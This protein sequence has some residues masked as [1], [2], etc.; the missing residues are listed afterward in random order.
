MPRSIAFGRI[1]CIRIDEF[2]YLL[3][4]VVPY[5]EPAPR[6]LAHRGLA[7]DAVENSLRAFEAA[8]D[9]GVNHIETDVRTTRDGVAVLW[10]D[11]DLAAVGFPDVRIRDIDWYELRAM[12][13]G[14]DGIARLDEALQVFPDLKFN[15]DLKDAGA[16][17]PVIDVLRSSQTQDRVLVTSFSDGR[18]TSLQREFPGLA[19]SP[20]IAA[21][22]RLKWSVGPSARQSRRWKRVLRG[23]VALQIPERWRGVNVLSR[24]LVDRAHELGL[25]VHVW[26]V[27]SSIRMTELWDFG[28]DA[29]VTDRSD[30]A[31][32]ALQKW[33]TESTPTAPPS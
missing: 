23:A 27:N 14:S 4:V 13:F 5:L 33:R 24:T 18:R 9:T 29:I 32:D 7:T 19:T 2:R 20:G 3:S 26:T 1:Q 11:R 15:I 31:A 16:V 10:H 28:V 12:R 22:A 8:R 25:A 6:I 30:L 17:Q 21:L